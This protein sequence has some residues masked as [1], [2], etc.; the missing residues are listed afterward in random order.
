MVA[1]LYRCRRP[2]THR[3][4]GARQGRMINNNNYHNN[5]GK[6]V[7]VGKQYP[8]AGNIF[9]RF[10]FFFFI[11][12]WHLYRYLNSINKIYYKNCVTRLTDILLR[13]SRFRRDIIGQCDRITVLNKKKIV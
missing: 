1:Y 10:F 9:S 2:R 8:S 13:L 5:Y 4:D 6:H 7:T 12:L 3:T 11:I